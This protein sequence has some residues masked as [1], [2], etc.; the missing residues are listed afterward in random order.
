MLWMTPGTVAVGVTAPVLIPFL[1]GEQWAPTA[2]I[3]AWLA[4]AALHR[5]VSMSMNFLFISQG[6]ARDYFIWSLFSA[7]TSIAAV[8]VGLRWGALG[9]AISFALSDVLL[10]LPALW[11]WVSRKGPVSQFDLYRAAAPFAAGSVAAFAALLALQRVTFSSSLF[12][13]IVS[14]IVAYAASWGVAALFPTGRKTLADTHQLART[15]LPRLMTRFRRA[16]P[17]G[18]GNVSM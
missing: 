12:E 4:L 6:R 5:P 13:L 8:V 9:V 1:I 15:E 10:R 3:F 14:A 11:W 18:S 7:A 16:P 17:Q 2:P